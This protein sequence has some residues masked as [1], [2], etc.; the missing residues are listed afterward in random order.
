MIPSPRIGRRGLILG[1]LAQGPLLRAGT[2]FAQA[3]V[4]GSVGGVV[5][6]VSAVGLVP[7][8]Y[9]TRSLFPEP[10]LAPPAPLPVPNPPPV[11]LQVWLD[12]AD[13]IYR[14]GETA[15]IAVESPVETFIQVLGLQ[16]EGPAIWLFPPDMLA[17]TARLPTEG[18]RVPAR[19][20]L[21]FPQPERHKFVLRARDPLGESMLF[22]IATAQ[23]LTVEQRRRVQRATAAATTPALAQGLLLPEL[24]AIRREQ[25]EL[26]LSHTGR[27][28]RTV[29]PE[30]DAAAPRGRALDWVTPTADAASLLRLTLPSRSYAAGDRLSLGLRTERACQL[31][32]LALGQGGMI[33]V[34][35]PNMR[36]SEAL[37]RGSEIV[38]PPGAGGIQLRFRGARFAEPE[39][40]RILAIARP[41]G[42]DHPFAPPTN[43]VP[44]LTFSPGSAAGLALEEMLRRAE[45]DRVIAEIRFQVGPAPLR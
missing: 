41:A 14:R 9:L 42:S 23:P 6:T 15:Q 26:R 34:L 11:E 22:V 45:T 2:A 31:V 5:G 44:T 13:G 43:G 33:D 35:Y 4:P 18:E 28:Y 24:D 39:E 10:L 21:L 8:P 27:N 32:V 30:G 17:D 29:P 38:L 25:P 1:G 20:P 16:A 7:P 3:R 19:T 12:H 37:A 40:E 36:Q